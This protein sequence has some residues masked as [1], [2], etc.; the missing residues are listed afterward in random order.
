MEPP[1]A[2]LAARDRFNSPD[3]GAAG[4]LGH[5]LRALPHRGDIA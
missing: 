3:V 4:A 2:V 5:E 1:L